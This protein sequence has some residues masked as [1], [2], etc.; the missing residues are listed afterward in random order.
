MASDN[1][2]YWHMLLPEEVRAL[3]NIV[4]SPEELTAADK[5]MLRALA[6]RLDEE[7]ELQRDERISAARSMCFTDDW[8]DDDISVDENAT[9]LNTEDGYWVQAWLWVCN[10]DVDEEIEGAAQEDN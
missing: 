4:N 2:G 1:N 10:D 9:V 6:G 8:G 5:S 3:H 7:R